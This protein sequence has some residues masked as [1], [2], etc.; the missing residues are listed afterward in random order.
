MSNEVKIGILAIVTIALSLWGYKFILGSNML[1]KSNIY[2]VVYDRVE[3]MQVGT[4]VRISGVR[5]GSVANVSL[6]EDQRV[7]VVL[8]MDRGVRIPKNTVATII[9]TGF[10]GGKAI[11]LVYDRPCS[12]DNCAESGDLLQGQTKGLVASMM[13]E[14]NLE[15]YISIIKDGLQDIIDTLNQRLLSEDSQSPIAESAR[16]LQ[17]TLENL[18]SATSQVD[19]LVRNSSKDIDG[20]MSSL[21][22]ITGNIAAK[23]DQISSIIDQADSISR[24][25]AT[26]NLKGTLQ[27]V[28]TAVTDLKNT[29][30]TAD[31]ALAGVSTTVSKINDGEGSLGK[32]LNDEELYQNINNLSSRADSLIDDFQDRPYRYMPLKSRRKVKKFDRQD[33][34]ETETSN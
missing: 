6:Q 29:L 7:L 28:N 18:K 8:D 3:G 26:A 34:Q 21:A 1:V 11:E 31:Q 9:S 22:S 32:L 25:L 2:K 15:G 10:M 33:Q 27:E 19:R 24:Q 12:G 30:Q 13:G 14:E 5:V 23:N 20:A 16:N 4:Q 17:S